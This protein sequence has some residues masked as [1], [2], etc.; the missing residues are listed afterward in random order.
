MNTSSHLCRPLVR[1]VL[2]VVLGL[3]LAGASPALVLDPTAAGPAAADSPLTLLA[4]GGPGTGE[5]HG[6]MGGPGP[7][8]PMGGPMRGGM[9]G[10]MGAHMGRHM[11]PPG[12]QLTEAQKDKM[13]ELHHAQQPA[14]RALMKTI[15]KAH[16]ELQSLVAAD[17]FDEARA[18]AVAASGAQAG[19][20][21]ALLHART[22]NAVYRLLT[23]EQRKLVEA[24]RPNGATP[25]PP[26]CMG[27]MH[28]RP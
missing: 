28:R 27:P 22:E 13:F 16:E 10:P 20:E 1:V 11:L 8:G 7:D 15:R 9:E 24:C 19:T 4:Q 5:M 2:A 26:A 21:L 12:V 23:P 18:R 6:P 14:M 25:P 17:S 3:G